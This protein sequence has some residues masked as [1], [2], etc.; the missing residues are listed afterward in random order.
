MSLL[1]IKSNSREGNPPPMPIF[2]IFAPHPLDHLPI[3]WLEIT[4]KNFS[5]TWNAMIGS[6][7]VILH[8]R[9]SLYLANLIKEGIDHAVQSIGNHIWVPTQ[10][11]AQNLGDPSLM[12]TPNY[13][14]LINQAFNNFLFF[15][16]MPSLA[17]LLSPTFIL[18][19]PQENFSLPT[20]LTL[21]TGR[22]PRK[23][24]KLI[25]K[26]PA[27]M[28]KE[29]EQIL[30]TY[31][32]LKIK[33]FHLEQTFL[34]K[35][36]EPVIEAIILYFLVDLRMCSLILKAMKEKSPPSSSLE[37]TKR[38]ENQSVLGKR[39]TVD[40]N[41]IVMKSFIIW[42][43]RGSNN[44]NFKSQ[45]TTLLKLHKPALLFLLETKMSDYKNISYALG[46]D[47]RL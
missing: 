35:F 33:A 34:R 36:I 3:S 18:C 32:E 19:L 45:C 43:I 8:L 11:L 4:L 5:V 17:S 2:M 24:K 16:T 42:N 28:P 27:T 14:L 41:P 13:N 40:Q 23:Y 38:R 12:S 39:K 22:K 15:S 26:S 9:D 30:D 21:Y 20:L 10:L 47:A 37:V 1:K 31:G 6:Q 7:P 46:F 29:L 44:V 25:Y